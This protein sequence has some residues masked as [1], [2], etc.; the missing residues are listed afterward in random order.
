[1]QLLSADEH[2]CE[3]E[4][5]DVP[6]PHWIFCAMLTGW[7]REVARASSHVEAMVKHRQ[8]RAKG[9][10]RCLWTVVWSAPVGHEL[11]VPSLAGVKK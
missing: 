4:V 7:M 11:F 5:T 10:T 2:V 6:E 9:A 8:C 3:L 1:M